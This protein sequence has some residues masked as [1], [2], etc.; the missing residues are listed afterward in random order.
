MERS[1]LDF[2]PGAKYH[3]ATF[4]PYARYFIANFN[5]FQFYKALCRLSTYRGPLHKCDFYNSQE[6]GAK[7]K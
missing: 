6:A 7:L 3:I 2:D 4:V 1:E 5:Q